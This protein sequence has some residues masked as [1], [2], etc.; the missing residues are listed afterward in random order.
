MGGGSSAKPSTE[1][2]SRYA[3]ANMSYKMSDI[4]R[5]SVKERLI[6][7]RLI[8]DGPTYGLDLVRN[9]DGELARGTVYVT[10]S[11]MADKGYVTS[12]L[13]EPRTG[14][15]GPPRRRFN[16]TGHGRRVLAVWELAGAALAVGGKR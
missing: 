16:V 9:S 11:R 5:L 1:L 4:P 10:L 6:M 3:R 2:A 7:E 15:Q 14:E 13:I 12:E 8:A